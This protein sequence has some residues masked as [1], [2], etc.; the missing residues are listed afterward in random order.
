MQEFYKLSELSEI[1]QWLESQDESIQTQLLAEFIRLKDYK[2]AV[3]WNHLVTICEAIT[4]LDIWQKFDLEPVEAYCG[5]GMSGSWET[6]LYNA[7]WQKMPS[8]WRDWSKNGDSFKI[9]QGAD[10]QNYGVLKLNSQRNLLPTN[11]FKIGRFMANFQQSAAAFVS[12]VEFLNYC[13]ETQM[14]PKL[15]GDGFYYVTINTNYSHHDWP[16]H[17]SVREEYVH[18]ESE[19][20]TDHKN[21]YIEPKI[22]Y[23]K[24]S[25]RQNRLCWKVNRN[26]NRAWGNMALAAQK[27]SLAEDLNIIFAELE[28][29]LSKKKVDYNVK[30]AIEHANSI[31]KQWLNSK[32]DTKYYQR[33]EIELIEAKADGELLKNF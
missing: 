8:S 1:K 10:I 21:Y 25:T 30:L 31:I 20:P 27:Q 33:I 28:T 13:L 14:Q 19:A 5:K 24:L 6:A 2:N 3:E 7:N 4:L 9:Y 32:A 15:Y 29:K 16:G 18:D 17:V 12:E 22:E 26:Y 23:G 11:P